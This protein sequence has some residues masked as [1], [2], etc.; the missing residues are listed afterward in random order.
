M[1]EWASRARLAVYGLAAGTVV[2]VC[3][4]GLATEKI[5]TVSQTLVA[6]TEVSAEEQQ[7][8]GLVTIESAGCSGALLNSE[9][10]I[11]AA[12]C[13]VDPTVPAAAV[14]IQANWPTKQSR[15]VSRLDLLDKDIAILRVVKPFDGI[16]PSFNMPVFTGTLAP[17]RGLRIYG[18]GIHIL[19]TGS[20]DTA[21]PSQRDGKYRV[22]DFQVSRVDADHFW[23]GPGK[24]GAIPAGG[25]SGGP[26]FIDAGGRWVLAGISSICMASR[27]KGKPDE[28]W[29]W[30]NKIHECGYAPVG[31]VWAEIERRIGS[32]A[33]RTYAWHAVGAVE[34]AKFYGCDPAVVSGPRWSPNFDEH[35]GWCM[36]A[37]PADV[38][39]E[40]QARTAIMFECRIAAAT[41][42]GTGALT[43]AETPDGFALSGGGYPVNA[44]IIIRSSARRRGSRT[45]PPTSPTRRGTSPSRSPA[46]KCAPGPAPSRSRPRTRTG[47]PRRR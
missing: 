45:S 40:D 20:G 33:C 32:A 24:G 7:A 44:R 43:V 2:A 23:F 35:L 29:D 27:I 22:A 17:G 6:G 46:P 18:R 10:V 31:A 28:G 8:Q 21:I 37:S 14:T 11:S 47:R 16:D 9:W 41:P 1:R 34:M 13:F 38:N 3:G 25:D 30:V 39:A 4:T 15:K 12:H 19:A 5:G 26:A 42:Q 36:Q